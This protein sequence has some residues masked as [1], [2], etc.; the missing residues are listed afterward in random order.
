MTRW[1]PMRPA[2]HAWLTELR[3]ELLGVDVD[4]AP[5]TAWGWLTQLGKCVAATALV[6]GVA[7]VL[8]LCVVIG[9]GR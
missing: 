6:V 4:E 2:H 1:N 8:C 7:L 3:C 9:G 5:T